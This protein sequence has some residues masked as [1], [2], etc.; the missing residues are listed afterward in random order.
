MHSHPRSS[1]ELASLLTLLPAQVVVIA[2]TGAGTRGTIVGAQA[3]SHLPA[4]E[5][6]DTRSGP[7]R[8]LG[9]SRI[10]AQATNVI[11]TQPY[12]SALQRA[13]SQSPSCLGAAVTARNTV[14]PVQELALSLGHSRPSIQASALPPLPC[15]FL[16]CDLLLYAL[17][18]LILK[19]FKIHWT[20]LLPLYRWEN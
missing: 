4:M 7:V 20:I 15:T 10:T 5:R 16:L 17:F 11:Q 13:C 9:K 3:V 8:V 6:K 19:P 14:I 18:C 2:L 1:P 12:L